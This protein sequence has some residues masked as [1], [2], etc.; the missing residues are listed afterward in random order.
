MREKCKILAKI[1]ITLAIIELFVFNFDAFCSY[2]NK[3]YSPS[4]VPGT[5]LEVCLDGRYLVVDEA[6]ATLELLDV[7][8]ELDYIRLDI[9]RYDS[10]GK[11]LPLTMNLYLADEGHYSYYH[12][13]TVTSYG[14]VETL[15]YHRLHPYGEVEKL[16][17]NLEVSN[18]QYIEI[19]AL[20]LEARV[21]FQI[22][23]P[24]LF[25]LALVAIILYAFQPGSSLYQLPLALE[26]KTQRGVLTGILFGNFILLLLLITVN[27]VFCESP[28]WD[29]HFQYH[30]L[31]E[32]LLQ[33]RTWLDYGN[34]EGLSALENPYDMQL[35]RDT[36]VPEHWDTA[37]FEGKYYVYFG[38]VPVLLFYLPCLLL[39]GKAFPTWIGIAASMTAIMI[40]A[41]YLL[42][43]LIKRYFPSVSFGHYL[44]LSLILGNG[45]GLVVLAMRPDFYTL[46]IVLALAFSLWGISFWLRAA[47]GWK[48]RGCI[49]FVAAGALCLALTAG[50]RPQFLMGSFLFFPILGRYFFKKRWHSREIKR[51]LAI[52][53]PYGVVAVLLMLYNY[54]RFGSPFDFGA[55]YNITTNDMTH[56]GFYLGRIGEGIFQYLFQM[57]VLTT[58]FPFVR[59]TYLTSDYLGQTIR[60]NFFGGLFFS[61]FVV[62]ANVFY[63][64]VKKKLRAKGLG[65]FW[66]ISIVGAVV[67]LAADTGLAGIVVRYMTDFSWLFFLGAFVVLLQLLAEPEYHGIV[68]WFLLIGFLAML[69]FDLSAGMQLTELRSFQ[70]EKYFEIQSFFR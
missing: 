66:W 7:Q 39:T 68:T 61:H 19:A 1:F 59:E 20:E 54:E 58:N 55:S 31:A 62:G 40:G 70:P 9:R 29:H 42:Y 12:Q 43:Q 23:L 57:P 18:G 53:I 21:P 30:R 37:F 65:L 15:T 49:G 51:F 67:I 2:A 22:S 32:S 45:T 52:A 41:F 64:S 14:E 28:R 60:E 69:F 13:G 46:P 8:A 34:T 44:L 10:F 24:R 47:R 36:G 11:T 63:P 5:G 27:P 50:C 25:V 17:L 38:I 48:K 26:G 35:R 56:R 4:F 33:G 3:G 16:R 6:A